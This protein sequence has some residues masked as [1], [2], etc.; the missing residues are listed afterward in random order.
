MLKQIIKRMATAIPSIIGV[1]IVTFLLTRVLPGDTA[2]YFAGPAAS[3]QAISEIRAKLGLDQPL[4]VQFLAYVKDLAT[5]N[6]G[7]SLTTGQPVL[8]DIRARLPASAELTL[9]G[10]LLSVLVAVPLGILAAV[11][12]G[13]WIDHLCRLVA[14]AGVSLPVFFTGLLLVYVFYF[15]L[16]W[17]PA[18]LGRLDFFYS[19]PETI[20]GF[21]LVDSLLAGDIEVF[22]AS[23]SQI[24][25]PAVTL[26]IFS[27]APIARMTRASM[28][29]VLAS[30][31]VRTA[32][33]SGLKPRKVVLGY[34]FRN[35]L[36]PVVT[37]LGMVFSFLLG[38]NVLVE[39]VFAWPGIGSY[40]IEALIT[41]DYAPVQGFVLAMAILYVLLNLL[42]DIVYGLIDPRVRIEA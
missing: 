28:L 29:A 19:P 30:D 8:D 10:L 31:F 41:S 14:T 26:A 32:R 12:Q 35:A 7:N 16:G 23:W 22:R 34:A 25:L 15:K 36:L 37:T 17:A 24:W 13:S 18:P 5:G 2:A 9:L 39:K 1:V 11:R 6:L 38:A 27:L 42:I 40:A 4:P 21:Y 3:E 33:A 20:T